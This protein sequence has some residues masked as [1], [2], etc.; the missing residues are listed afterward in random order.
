MGDGA[1]AD[2]AT[3]VVVCWGVEDVLNES[4][5]Q[6]TGHRPSVRATKKRLTNLRARVE[7]LLTE[8]NATDP[9]FRH[10]LTWSRETF[11]RGLK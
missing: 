7:V 3:A 10:F 8:R 9:D 4:K 1:C 6:L 2:V 5:H 11:V